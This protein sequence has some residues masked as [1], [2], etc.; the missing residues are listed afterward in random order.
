MTKFVQLTS[1]PVLPSKNINY[2]RNSNIEYPKPAFPHNG[3]KS[4]GTK[5]E[6]TIPSISNKLLT[7]NY[8]AQQAAAQ[9]PS[10]CFDT[11]ENA[12]NTKF[13]VSLTYS[14]GSIK[15]PKSLPSQPQER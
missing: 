6:N 9:P 3:L 11:T 7:I 12:N 1:L 13:I 8:P 5:I 2:I 15:K 10:Q 14:S 4:T